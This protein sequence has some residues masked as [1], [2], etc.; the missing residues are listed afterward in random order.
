M[1]RW[2]IFTL[3]GKNYQLHSKKYTH[4]RENEYIKD[5]FWYFS[6]KVH[7]SFGSDQTLNILKI[8]IFFPFIFFLSEFFQNNGFYGYLL[9]LRRSKPPPTYYHNTTHNAWQKDMAEIRPSMVRN[10]KENN[11][12]RKR[13]NNSS[14]G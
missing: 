9:R 4:Q 14:I 1:A 11:T 5:L 2:Y 7:F 12:R 6:S 3:T 10:R 13:R 8:L